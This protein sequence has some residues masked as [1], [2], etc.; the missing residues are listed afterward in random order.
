MLKNYVF[1]V[2]FMLF[3]G[4]GA[5]AMESSTSQVQTAANATLSSAVKAFKATPSE[6]TWDALLASLKMLNIGPQAVFQA[7]AEFSG[8]GIRAIDAGQSIVWVYPQNTPFKAVLVQ[9]REIKPG[10][11]IKARHHH[12][13]HSAPIVTKRSQI[14][15]LPENV[16]VKEAKMIDTNGKCLLLTGF[17]GATHNIWLRSYKLNE[18][19]TENNAVLTAI[20]PFLLNNISGRVSFS[21][22]DIILTINSRGQKSPSTEGNEAEGLVYKLPLHLIDGKY[23]LEGKPAAESPY[24]AVFQF[25]Q[26]YG[27]AKM[28][29]AK[30]WLAD[31]SLISVPKYSGLAGKGSGASRIISIS[32]AAPGVY[33]FRLITFAND[34]LV[35]DVVKLKT[36]WAIKSIF[37]APADL[38]WQHIAKNLTSVAVG[39]SGPDMAEVKSQAENKISIPR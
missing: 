32:G 13:I 2:A 4:L 18:N 8:L 19:W 27:Q 38:L 24:N 6:E 22:K 30:V 26:A 17:E 33:R 28:E 1:A 15:N 23:Q 3:Y 25:V 39:K 5:L 31:P 11:T 36:R 14:L 12:I 7:N 29:L 35:F 16:V 10:K 9:W 20:P 37:I 21:G 34:D